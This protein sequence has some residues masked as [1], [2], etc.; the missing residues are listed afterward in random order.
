MNLFFLF[1]SKL[2]L[3]NC[4][5]FF[6][7]K[8]MLSK[9]KKKKKSWK[10]ERWWS[11]HVRHEKCQ[12]KKKDLLPPAICLKSLKLIDWCCFSW[13]FS[14]KID[15]WTF[16]LLLLLL[17]DTF[18]CRQYCQTK[19][20]SLS[21]WFLSLILMKRKFI[22]NFK[23]SRQIEKENQNS[24]LLAS[25]TEN[26]FVSILTF[27]IVHFYHHHQNH[28]HHHRHHHPNHHY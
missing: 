2:W 21:L 7:L 6:Y 24:I 17:L 25:W 14:L 11:K 8:Q 18:N 13:F 23:K 12:S 4:N 19:A 9:K 5:W 27:F 1:F 20:F 10:G 28:H 22:H 16:F 26:N 15:F 3:S